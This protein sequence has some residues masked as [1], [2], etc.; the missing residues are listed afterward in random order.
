[1]GL[2]C[3]TH[4]DAPLHAFAGGAPV[5]EL[6]LEA[7]CGPAVVADLQG[8]GSIGAD[9][10]ETLHLAPSVERLLLRTDNS[11]LWREG[12]RFEPDYVGLT[13]DGAHW[14]VDRGIGLLGVD[15]LSV[16][17]FADDFE[18]HR[19]LLAARVALLEG[20]ALEHVSPGS[21]ELL[22]LPLKF[23]GPEAAPARAILL[24]S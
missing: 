10:L 8:A 2:H 5:E 9:E 1:M 23:R 17:R 21:C 16:Q 6:A 20:L 4:V 24:M 15:C 13:L 3:G 7:L 19:V 22:C 12:S 14:L 18:T 11:R